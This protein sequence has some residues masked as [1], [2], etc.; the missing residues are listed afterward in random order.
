M[1]SFTSHARTCRKSAHVSASAETL[2]APAAFANASLYFPPRIAA[3]RSP[4]PAYLGAFGYACVQRGANT[5]KHIG[6]RGVL[7]DEHYGLVG[8]D[9]LHMHQT[10][11]SINQSTKQP[12][13]AN[14]QSITPIT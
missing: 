4:P 12:H 2:P 1:T 9:D 14:N 8:A 6:A 10:I 7:E 3:S 13:Q 5:G 11:Q